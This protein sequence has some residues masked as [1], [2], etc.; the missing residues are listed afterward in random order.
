V[1][2]STVQNKT[3]SVDDILSI[4]DCVD[5]NLS[6]VKS[7]DCGNEIDDNHECD[8]KNG[9]SDSEQHDRQAVSVTSR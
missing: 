6:E 2:S 9:T 4:L 8:C 1:V 3:I 5:E 7:S